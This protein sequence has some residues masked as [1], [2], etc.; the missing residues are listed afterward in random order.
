MNKKKRKQRRD[1]MQDVEQTPV[2]EETR[3]EPTEASEA[4]TE[5]MDADAA[6][7]PAAE[8]AEEHPKLAAY[9][10]S[11]L[12]MMM[13]ISSIFLVMDGSPE[14]LGQRTELWE[15]LRTVDSELYHKMKYR[16]ISAVGCFP[17]Y[18]GRKLSLKLYRL[19]Q[20]IYKFN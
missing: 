14:K 7:E 12:S 11:Y 13:T 4:K 18:Q 15:Y 8:Q 6:K 5:A 9:M 3:V 16:S 2:T 17:G 10:F 1:N 19:A 20:R